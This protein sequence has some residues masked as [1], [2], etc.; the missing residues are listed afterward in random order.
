MESRWSVYMIGRCVHTCLHVYM[1]LAAG[2][3]NAYIHEHGVVPLWVVYYS[4]GLLTS[5]NTM[6]FKQKKYIP[7]DVTIIFSGIFKVFDLLLKNKM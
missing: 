7:F 4:S 2:A 6:L 1:A 5:S 3:Y